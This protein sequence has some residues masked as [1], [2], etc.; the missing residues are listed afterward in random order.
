MGSIASW[1]RRARRQG[2]FTLIEMLVVI[3][4]LGV[5]AMTVTLSMVGVVAVAHQRARDAELMNIQSAMNFMMMDQQIA[6]EDVCTTPPPATAD[7]AHF[8]VDPVDQGDLSEMPPKGTPAPLYPRYL[9]GQ[10]VSRLYV[11]VL[12]GTVRAASG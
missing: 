1:R 11:C 6:P 2:G 8:P 10:I 5:L 4:I 3:A 9:R 12:G 7:M